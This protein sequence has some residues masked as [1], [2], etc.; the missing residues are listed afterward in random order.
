MRGQVLQ[1]DAGGG[2]IL[3]EDGN[4]YRF[5]TGEWKGTPPAMTGSQVDFVIDGNSA[6]EVFPLAAGGAPLTLPASERGNS[7]LL[8]AL[9]VACLVVNFV[10]PVIPLILALILGL[11]GASSA[12]TYNNR[13]GLVLSRIAWIGAVVL[14]AVLVAL[15][16]FGLSFALP[17]LH[18]MLNNFRTF[19]PG[20]GTTI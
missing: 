17:I 14:M 1:S 10:I 19:I 3:G 8:G 12:K 20:R 4:R 9:G 13:T 2:L 7:E 15:I 18:D 5:A 6:R 16:A 11:I